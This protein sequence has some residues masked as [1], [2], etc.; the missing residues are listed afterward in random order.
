MTVKVRK[1]KRIVILQIITFLI[2]LF[3]FIDSLAT[4]ARE[5]IWL[6][7]GM[8]LLQLVI[9]LLR[10]ARGL[11][12]FCRRAAVTVSALL[13]VYI[14]GIM[15]F[16]LIFASVHSAN[17]SASGVVFLLGS[18]MKDNQPGVLYESRIER[19]I[20]YLNE[21]PFSSLIVCGGLTGEN[22]VTEAEAAYTRITQS[23]IAADRLLTEDSSARTVDNF[24][25]AA[26]LLEADGHWDRSVPTSII[27]N[28]F[29]FY[30]ASRLASSV[31]FRE[32]SLIPAPC[33]VISSLPWCIRE[34]MAVTNFWLIGPN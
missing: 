1:R 28:R 25:F 6:T 19:A 31:G 12:R 20:S 21:N 34:V 2:W 3:V 11:L 5:A 10:R 30:R 22:T 13:H 4:G 18:D 8:C 24:D 23:G 15:L 33:K 32:I 27:T 26:S 16:L 9:L 29:H 14:I 7:G 17:A